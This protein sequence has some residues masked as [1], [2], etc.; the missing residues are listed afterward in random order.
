MM[1][2]A[3]FF[4]RLPEPMVAA[5]PRR[6]PDLL[7]KTLRVGLDIARRSQ[8]WH[9]FSEIYRHDRVKTLRVSLPQDLLAEIAEIEGTF[10]EARRCITG[11][12]LH[13]AMTDRLSPGYS[14]RLV[15]LLAQRG[16]LGPRLAAAG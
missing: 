7:L 10:G 5:L 12:A 13:C 6:K 4:V 2:S 11:Y 3:P 14:P 9:R 8:S 15:A 1:A 16:P